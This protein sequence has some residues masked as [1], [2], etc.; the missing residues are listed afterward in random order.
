MPLTAAVDDASPEQIIGVRDAAAER[1]SARHAIA[2]VDATGGAARRPDTGRDVLRVP[3]HLGQPRRRKPPTEQAA[4]RGDR[5]APA[6]G[7]VTA[8]N[9]LRQAQRLRRG[10][11]RGA[12]R[13][14]GPRAEETRHPQARD[15][16]LRE[17]PKLLGL[18]REAAG[19]RGQL[20]GHAIQV[21]HVDSGGIEVGHQQSGSVT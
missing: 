6:R 11:L 9:G 14:R 15:E 20:V 4:G 8:R 18:G 10:S 16:L 2:T 17:A 21:L 13:S 7:G 19:E 12:S 1:P 5:H 3:E